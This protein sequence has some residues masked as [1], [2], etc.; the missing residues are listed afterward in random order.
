[1]STIWTKRIAHTGPYKHTELAD[2]NER[3]KAEG[4]PYA[5]DA[6]LESSRYQIC[7]DSDDTK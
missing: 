7:T 4:T 3:G 2:K 6:L 1:V 5:D